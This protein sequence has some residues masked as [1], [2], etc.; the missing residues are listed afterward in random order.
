MPA[1]ALRT[2]RRRVAAMKDAPTWTD[3]EL[4]TLDALV[5][6][7]LDENR[8]QVARWGTQTHT[9]A[10]W[11][12]I[13]S[14]EFGELAQAL[15]EAHF[16]PSTAALD[17]VYREAIQAATLALKCAEMTRHYRRGVE[18]TPFDLRDLV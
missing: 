16:R 11:S 10:E 13:T 1:L 17:A 9:V 15:C 5:S 8:R 7:V 4:T 18:V 12:A 6:H 14:E 2:D 3:Q